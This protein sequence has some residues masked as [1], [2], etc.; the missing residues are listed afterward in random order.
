[1]HM[2]LFIVIVCIHFFIID[3]F[4]FIYHFITITII[5]PNIFSGVS[6]MLARI[7][8]VIPLVVTCRHS[9]LLVVS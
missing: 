8:L 2:H 9:L 7:S 6:L 4:I 3:F 5:I 1:M